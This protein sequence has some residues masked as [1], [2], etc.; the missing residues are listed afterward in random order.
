MKTTHVVGLTAYLVGNAS[1]F[2]FLPSVVVWGGINVYKLFAITRSIFYDQLVQRGLEQHRPVVSANLSR[3]VEE[4]T[5]TALK[6]NPRLKKIVL[7]TGLI[8]L[9]SKLVLYALEFY[10]P[11]D[12]FH[13]RNNR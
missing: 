3:I 9:I 8:M 12:D 10:E 13:R 6:W 4:S 1:G 11:Y 5:A 2:V 7:V